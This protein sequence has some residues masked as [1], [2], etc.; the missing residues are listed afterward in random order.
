MA[1][2]PATQSEAEGALLGEV[3]DE[4]AERLR[5]GERPDLDEYARRHPH[6]AQLILEG[7]PLLE[8]IGPRKTAPATPVRSAPERI[9]EYRVGRLIGRG[10]MG[11]VYEAEQPGLGR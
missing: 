4:V 10:G 3:A 7:L 5:N 2:P 9:G 1:D 11:A 8:M 6:I